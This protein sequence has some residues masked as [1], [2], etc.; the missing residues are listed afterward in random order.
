MTDGVSGTDHLGWYFF[1]KGE[2]VEWTLSQT[3]TILESTH[4]ASL[5]SV[6]MVFE[7]VFGSLGFIRYM[8]TFQIHYH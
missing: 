5:A 7:E 6:F 8:F 1:V 2:K 3:R 4:P